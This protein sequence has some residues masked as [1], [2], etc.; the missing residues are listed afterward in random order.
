MENNIVEDSINFPLQFFFPLRPKKR[1]KKE[2]KREMF[3]NFNIFE[4]NLLSVE[5]VKVL[6]LSLPSP[7]KLDF[8]TNP[9]AI[10]GLRQDLLLLG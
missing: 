10:S 3:E 7:N 2:K 9:S 8:W 1:K 6:A 5:T 4:Y